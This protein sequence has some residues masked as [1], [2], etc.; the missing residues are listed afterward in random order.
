MEIKKLLDRDDVKN[1][2]AQSVAKRKQLAA[3]S[4]QAEGNAQPLTDDRVSRS[5][6]A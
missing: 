1:N 6:F 2:T 4:G 3:Y 5:Q